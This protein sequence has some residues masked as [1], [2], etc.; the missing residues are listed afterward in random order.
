[1][2]LNELHDELMAVPAKH[3]IS[4]F[5]EHLIIKRIFEEIGVTNKFLVDIG[6]G[7]NGNG[8][9]SNSYD[10]IENNGWD[11]ILLDANKGGYDRIKEHFIEP[12][13]I[14]GILE[15][16]NCP[17]KFDFLS[18]DI[19]GF[20]LDVMESVMSLYRPRMI[21]TEYNG[22]LSDQ[23]C[24]KLKYERGY[25]WDGTNKYGYSFLA[26]CKFAKKHGYKVFMNHHNMNLFLICNSVAGDYDKK[27]LFNQ[28]LYHAFNPK[29]E[30]V[31]YN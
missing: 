11:G 4:Q 3:G 13:N 14:L 10:L 12:D 31:E 22:T 30:W 21:C 26:G 16:Y 20:D 15:S 17:A 1:M 2:N 5:G 19:D 24:V 25:T 28:Q 18:I 7:Y 27:I 6:A 23:V 29:A 9:L 8:L